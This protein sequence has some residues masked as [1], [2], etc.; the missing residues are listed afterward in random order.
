[1]SSP[2]IL[3]TGGTGFIGRYVVGRL[4]S[5]GLKPILTTSG[6]TA[7]DGTYTLDLTDERSAESLVHK[8][9]PDIVLHLGGVTGATTD[10]ELCH[11]VNYLG[12]VNL[13]NAI[14]NT[15]ISR[16]VLIGTAAEY[17][18]QSTPFREDMA[19]K[20]VSPYAQS[21]ARANEYALEM[22]GKMGLP[23]TI[24]R[25]FT[26]YGYGQPQKMFLSQLIAHALA[27][28]RF[29]MS[30]G[31]QKRDFVHV[32]DVARSVVLAMQTDKAVGRVINIGSGRAIKL[33]DLA[34][35]VWET[36]RAEPGQLQIGIRERT[37]DDS[38]DTEAD[39]SLAAE[40]LDWHPEMP[41]IAEPHNPALI[42]MIEKMRDEIRSASTFQ[43]STAPSTAG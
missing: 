18:Q 22:H 24:L 21:K 19:P 3:V 15:N 41:F 34:Y 17:G 26:A 39:I 35:R 23:V 12:T 31:R 13:L 28:E 11:A 9:K 8:V 10:A 38:F 27:S 20:P 32:D 7:T 16:I 30:D 5:D 2:K 33:R 36:C 25:V 1:M 14:R 43:M 29:T 37:G 4:S 6:E 40:L 42:G